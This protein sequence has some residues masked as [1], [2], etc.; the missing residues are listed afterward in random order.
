MQIYQLLAVRALCDLPTASC[1]CIV[2][3]SQ[4]HGWHF[5]S[6]PN[7]TANRRHSYWQQKVKEKPENWNA[8]L[9]GRSFYTQGNIQKIGFQLFLYT[10]SISTPKLH[11]WK[12]VKCRNLHL[13]EYQGWSWTVN[14]EA[15]DLNS[16]H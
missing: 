1:P 2:T 14:S 5:S 10:T 16:M 12:M 9:H 15:K 8:L 13:N 4:L 6:A 11:W 7:S 3:D